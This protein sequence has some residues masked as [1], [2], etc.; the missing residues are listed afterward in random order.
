MGLA[1]AAGF[2]AGF[3]AIVGLVP[4]PPVHVTHWLLWFALGTWLVFSILSLANETA[5]KWGGFLVFVLIALILLKPFFDRWGTG[6]IIGF[7]GGL[8]LYQFLLYLAIPKSP[9]Q[10][11]QAPTFWIF[12]VAATGA[13]LVH[14]MDGG[15]LSGQ[16]GGVLAASCGGLFLAS[17]FGQ[18]LRAG[19]VSSGIFVTL[20]GSSMVHGYLYVEVFLPAILL[21]ALSPFAVLWYRSNRFVAWPV[22]KKMIIAI[23]TASLPV[24]IAIIWLLSR[25]SQDPYGY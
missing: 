17:C 21:V 10:A 4:F 6:T 24:A 11:K 16:L 9:H 7:V 12:I 18:G 5:A 14:V 23:V 25:A 8:C 22:W 1:L 19:L 13:S 2:S 3:L 15:A 20:F